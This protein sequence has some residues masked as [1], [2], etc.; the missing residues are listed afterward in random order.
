MQLRVVVRVILHITHYNILVLRI[1]LM[2]LLEDIYIFEII[3]NL[4]DFL[5]YGLKNYIDYILKIHSYQMSDE[6]NN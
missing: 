5:V 2:S 4:S 3:I 6:T 1:E